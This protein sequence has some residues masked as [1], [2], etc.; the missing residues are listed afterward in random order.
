MGRFAHLHHGHP[1][2][3]EGARLVRADSRGV[4]HRLARVQVPHQVVVSHHFLEQNAFE[5]FFQPLFS[6][7]KRIFNKKKQVCLTLG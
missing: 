2:G 5:F 4:P 3:G 7:I 1:V 6:R